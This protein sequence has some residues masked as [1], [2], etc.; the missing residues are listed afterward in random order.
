MPV[1]LFV[2]F[3]LTALA[4]AGGLCALLMS[5]PRYR[6]IGL[7]GPCRKCG[8]SDGVIL[9]RHFTL[10]EKKCDGLVTR[11]AETN[12]SGWMSQTSWT[13]GDTHHHGHMTYGGGPINVSGTTM[14]QQRVPVIRTKKLSVYCCKY[15]LASWGH[16]STDEVEDFERS[17]FRADLNAAGN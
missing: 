11:V 12:S 14:Q 4:A 10:E 13:P 7:D 5:L 15:C 3:A 2:G 8:L 16:S 6:R 1:V 17:M 9:L